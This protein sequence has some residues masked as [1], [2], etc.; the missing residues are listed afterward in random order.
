M[1]HERQLVVRNLLLAGCAGSG[2]CHIVAN[3]AILTVNAFEHHV[4]RSQGK[5]RVNNAVHFR[6]V[7]VLPRVGASRQH[8]RFRQ[9]RH[10][11]VGA[12]HQRAHRLA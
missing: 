10:Q 11:H 3:D 12:I 2:R 8:G 4:F 1:C 9:I 6:V 5:Q 7:D